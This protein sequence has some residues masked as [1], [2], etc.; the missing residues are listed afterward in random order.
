MTDKISPRDCNAVC[1]V[2][3]ALKLFEGKYSSM[4]LLELLSG[5]KRFSELQKNITGIS[6]KTLNEK[7]KEYIRLGIVSRHS[8]A[9]IPPKVEYRLTDKGRR[10]EDI[11]AVLHRFGADENTNEEKIQVN[12]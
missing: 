5:K 9:E 8:F 3:K 12:A 10:L 6:S 7:L 4:I 2:Q 11:I 1:P